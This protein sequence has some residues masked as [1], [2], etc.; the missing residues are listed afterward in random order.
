[1]A[2]EPIAAT[3]AV[4][5]S[6]SIT[7]RALIL[8]ALADGPS[9]LR[10]PLRSRD[11][12]LMAAGL[13][14]LGVTIEDEGEGEGAPWRVTPTPLRGGAQID[15]GN[16]GTVMRFLPAVAAL[17]DGPVTFDGDQRSHERPLGALLEALARLGARVEDSGTGRIPFTLHGT[18]Q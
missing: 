18:G 8:A 13:R 16:A 2:S 1:R 10:R 15:V 5:G 17:A 14:Q 9:L 4:P 7:N 3:V 11:T 6:K 12:R